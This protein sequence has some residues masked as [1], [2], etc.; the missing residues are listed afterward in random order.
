M[1][2]TVGSIAPQFSTE[3]IFGN[4]LSLEDYAGQ[5]LLLSFFRN[6]ACAI[7]NLQVHKLIQKYPEY[8]EHGLEIIAVFESPR[9]S[10][11]ANVQKQD[12]PFT[13]IADPDARLYKLYG[14]ENSEEKVMASPNPERRNRIIEE[15]AAIGYQ[16]IKEDGQNFFRMP[17]DFLIG[18]DQHIQTAF[19]SEDIGE[20]I[21]FETIEHFLR[22][23]A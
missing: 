20:H 8:H 21:S 11:L 23:F 9:E 18:P 12:V 2:L 16:L 19:Y 15:A 13:L 10:V 17:A 4:P 5:A 3:D 1:K 14:V 22:Q 6:G 7:C